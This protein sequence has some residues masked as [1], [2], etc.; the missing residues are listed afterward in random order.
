MTFVTKY[1]ST[2]PHYLGFMTDQ[3][4]ESR[5]KGMKKNSTIFLE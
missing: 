4:S 2:S 1:K 5:G 3:P